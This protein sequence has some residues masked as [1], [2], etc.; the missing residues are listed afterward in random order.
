MLWHATR[1]SRW[2]R[3][4]LLTG[5]CGQRLTQH[6]QLGFYYY[7]ERTPAGNSVGNYP[8]IQSPGRLPHMVFCARTTMWVTSSTRDAPCQSLSGLLVLK[9]PHAAFVRSVA[10]RD[11]GARFG[12]LVDARDTPRTV[13][14]RTSSLGAP[15]YTPSHHTLAT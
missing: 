5:V 12:R 13:R 2:P 4:S 1:A 9:Q 11:A 7:P 3:C 15:M 14:C 10:P 8:D 6:L